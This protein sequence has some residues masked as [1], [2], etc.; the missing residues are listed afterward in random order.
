MDV[1]EL[2][3]QTIIKE[4]ITKDNILDFIED[5]Q[6]L[7]AALYMTNNQKI[8]SHWETIIAKWPFLSKYG[9]SDMGQSLKSKD[10]ITSLKND[11]TSLNYAEVILAFK[12]DYSFCK[13]LQN[14]LSPTDS[15]PLP[16][17]ITVDKSIIGGVTV[18]YN[19]NYMDMSLIK[20]LDNFI[21][22]NK[23]YVLSKL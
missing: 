4:L 12:P 20:I 6:N 9:L 21:N 13:E 3:S 17:V 16:L 11:L 22:S 14:M 8:A 2:N 5:L 7:E 1:K 19:G 10:S 23:E 15:S 18:S